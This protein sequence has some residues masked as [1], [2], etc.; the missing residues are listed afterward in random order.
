MTGSQVGLDARRARALAGATALAGAAVSVACIGLGIWARGRSG[1]VWPAILTDWTLG[2]CLL[3]LTASGVGVVV[4]TRL[5]RNVVGWLFLLLGVLTGLVFGL[6]WY[7]TL[8]M[9]GG[10]P[11]AA[12]QWAAWLF[13]WLIPVNMT[14]LALVS[15]LFPHGTPPSRRWRPFTAT[16]VLI[17]VAATIVQVVSP[18]HANQTPFPQLRN[19]TAI[20]SRSVGPP[21]VDNVSTLLVLGMLGAA[22][23]PVV[24]MRRSRGVERQQVKWFVFSAAVAIP[25]IFAGFWSKPAFVLATLV[26]LPAVPVAAGL[27]IL[28][29]RLYD[30]DRVINRT[31]VYG[32]V[33]GVLAVAYLAAVATMRAVTSPWTGDTA[34]SVAVSTLAVAALFRPLRNR[35]QTAVDRRFN[36]GRYD[37]TRTAEA[38]RAR[39]REQLDLEAITTDLEATASATVQPTAVSVWLTPGGS[40]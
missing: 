4:T 39:L 17:G 29:Y 24:R 34:V 38:Y 14:C 36:R 6:R 12:V 18:Y 28:R 11:T 26:A 2:S 33:T 10:P 16:L 35:I 25:A 27:A 15:L 30:I 9:V 32:V 22:I 19:P 40:R 31:V 7:T 1:S 5:P 3:C 23:A 20:L 8:M 13:A 37:A 21:L